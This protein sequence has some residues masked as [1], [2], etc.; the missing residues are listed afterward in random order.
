M[1]KN[2]SVTRCLYER[3]DLDTVKID[4][5][6]KQLQDVKEEFGGDAILDFD[7]GY[8]NISVEITYST[9]VKT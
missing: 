5:L 2:G 4:D 7:A 9:E 8:N 1:N 3:L 6:I